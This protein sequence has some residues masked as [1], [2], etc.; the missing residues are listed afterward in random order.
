MMYLDKFF[1]SFNCDNS[2]NFPREVITVE[3]IGDAVHS[4]CAVM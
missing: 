4:P 1:G 3:L 2:W